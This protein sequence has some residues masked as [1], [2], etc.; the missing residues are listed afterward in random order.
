MTAVAQG[1][2]TGQTSAG[3]ALELRDV[4]VGYGPCTVVGGVSFALDPGDWVAIIGPNGAGK[5]TVLKAIVGLLDF[6]GS[7]TV[8]GQPRAPGKLGQSAAAIAY[9][10]QRPILPPG[11]TTAEY[12]LLGRT[13]H[14]GWLQSESAADRQRVT[15]VLEQ[16]DLAPMA[17]RQVSELSG[18][19]SQ[20]VTLARALVQEATVLVLD[21]PTSSLDLGHQVSVL[22]VL[23]RLR[24]DH[25]LAVVT[26]IH[27][28]SIASRFADQLVLVA[29]RG[30]PAIGTPTEVL[31]EPILSRYYQTPVAV[32][33]APDGGMVVLPL[34]TTQNE[35]Q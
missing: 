7:I 21:E 12:V 15:D 32:M 20:R 14:L 16:L 9:V 13:A 24:R 8:A 2:S 17:G 19:E 5:S 25:D 18:G 23:D 22:E 31:T 35:T 33:D 30:A 10:P 11:M 6:E 29:D 4:S 27:D 1:A 26:A 3:S 34:R 28:L